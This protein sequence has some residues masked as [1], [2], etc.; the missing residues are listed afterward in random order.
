MRAPRDRMLL[1]SRAGVL[2]STLHAGAALVFG[3]ALEEGGRRL[4]GIPHDRATA[5]HLNL[6]V[7][8]WLTLLLVTVGR[9]L[10]PM[11]SLA[12]SAPKRRA[13]SRRLR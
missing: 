7:L 8:G 6:A 3:A 12:P 9:T 4:W 13:P 10:G 2:L 1:A 5:I 11:L